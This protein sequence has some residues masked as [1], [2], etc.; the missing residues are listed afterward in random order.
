[1]EKR[2]KSPVTDSYNTK[3][4]KIYSKEHFI[5]MY[6][7]SINFDVS[8]F[9][10]EINEILYVKC[11]D[12]GYKFFYPFSISGDELFYEDLQQFEWYYKQ[13]KW[14]F[15]EA[16]FQIKESDK[17]L[18]IGAG[19]GAFLKRLIN[20][21]ENI[22]A[23]EFNVKSLNILK[24]QGYHVY[25]QTIQKLAQTKEGYYDVVVSFQVLEHIS[26]VKSFI[27]ASIKV[28]KKGGQ[29][30]FSVPNDDALIMKLDFNLSLNFPPHHMGHWNKKTFFNLQ[31]YFSIQCVN[32]IHEPLQKK[33]YSRYYRVI[34]L[35]IRRKYGFIG[36]GIDKFLLYPYSQYFI[37]NFSKNLKGLS[38]VVTFIK[39]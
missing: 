14:E 28:L 25:N 17:I 19:N 11:L 34:A 8:R 32:F 20:K 9:F 21:K 33:Q 30:I 31:K 35:Y 38:L 4:L 7:K 13:N 24:K 23:I 18:E 5:E 27:E 12:T 29:M 1:M 39:K 16:L 10:T 22:D 26:D 3:I 37:R 6:K 2:I 15:E 36:R